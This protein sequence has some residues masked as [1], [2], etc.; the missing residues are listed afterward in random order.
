MGSGVGS[1]V[2]SR[3]G[4]S[5]GAGLAGEQAASPRRQNSVSP[6]GIRNPVHM[7]FM[8]VCLPESML[9]CDC[10]VNIRESAKTCKNQSKQ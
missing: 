3:V 6:N 9:L 1:A 8:I 7:R 4:V 10:C 2:V 5:T